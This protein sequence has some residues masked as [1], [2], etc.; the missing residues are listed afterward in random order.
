MSQLGNGTANV[1][2]EVSDEV[3]NGQLPVRSIQLSLR[4]V[5]RSVKEKL[6]SSQSDTAVHPTLAEVIEKYQASICA[7]FRT[8]L[9]LNNDVEDLAQEVFV[10]YYTKQGETET[11]SFDLQSLRPWLLGIARNV[12]REHLRKLSSRREILW[13][14][15]C[16][17]Q[18]E[19]TP[20]EFPCDDQEVMQD[21]R[22]CIENLGDSARQAL[23]LKYGHDKTLKEISG[24]LHRSE[25]AVKLLVFR[26]RQTL[27]RCLDF[28]HK[29]RE[30]TEDLGWL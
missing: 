25:G 13:T 7:Y 22:E 23:T 30:H 27:K 24:K 4:S 16:L 14:E 20:E 1:A 15:F 26:A 19:S 9:F 21:L 17:E 2:P 18:E 28:K 5:P 29:E 3:P 6:P 10:R 11:N 12:L 8:R